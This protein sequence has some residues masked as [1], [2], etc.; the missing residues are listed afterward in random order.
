MTG[1]QRDKERFFR[2]LISLAGGRVTTLLVIL[3]KE[4]FLISLSGPG[5]LAQTRSMFSSVAAAPTV[6]PTSRG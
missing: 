4:V 1:R 3:G 5:A 6:G 2:G